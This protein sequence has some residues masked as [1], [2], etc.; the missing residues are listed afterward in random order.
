MKNV[1][2]NLERY[3]QSFINQKDNWNFFLGLA[4]YLKYAVET[5][6]I[7]NVLKR[8]VQARNNDQK[9]LKEYE[10]K[11]IKETKEAKEKLF[12]IIKKHK[13]SNGVL[14]KEI[15]E[16]QGYENGTTQSSRTNA[17]ALSDALMDIIRSLFKSGYKQLVKDFAIEH[18]E[19]SDEVGKYTF[20]K[21]LDL[22]EKEKE[23]FN[24]KMK[25]ELWASW[26]DLVLAYLTVYKANEELQ[27]LR[28][29]E[30]DFFK[31]WNFVGLVGEMRKI[32]DGNINRLTS[33]AS[34]FEP[35]HFKKENYISHATR[36]HNYLLKELNLQL[37]KEREESQQPVE[38]FTNEVVPDLT[39]D[40]HRKMDEARKWEVERWERE[41]LHK[42][43]MKQDRILRTPVD[44][45]T[46]ALDLII[47]RAE[48]A[49]DGNSFSIEF[50]DFNFEQMIGSRMLEKFLDE[51]QNNGCFE[52]YIRTNYSGGTRFG[53]TKVN[54]KNLKKFK[55]KRG[56]V[57]EEKI[58]KKDF[59]EHE[60]IKK[61]TIIKMNND[62]YLFAINDSYEEV[63][64]ISDKSE[65]WQIFI[66]EVAERNMRPETRTNVK[67]IPKDMA[68]YFNY[69][70]EKCPIY[71]NGKYDLTNIF[72]GRDI[73][74]NI[75]SNIKTETISEKKYLSRKQKQTN[76]KK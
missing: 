15:K 67:E 33:I 70:A 28:K 61:I 50:Y 23:L 73:D 62:K 34:D 52:K 55:E 54:I 35:V 36:I 12:K 18:K 65:W 3:Y 6:E 20:S 30:K 68:D 13:I 37:A 72:V 32:R 58:V 53:F 29:D 71:M 17:E 39:A 44:E 64:K 60:S 47:K 40:I 8:I 2:E 76:S 10:Q 14:D 19:V 42:E 45:Y 25:T 49:E 11:V 57:K 41:K 46:H 43:E 1:I 74:I 21:T 66:K 26:N 75:N 16:Y 5:K 38:L 51:L 27:K 69:N 59:K 9:K 48:Y 22:Y 24:E 56:K 4:D 7:D 63:K 31:A